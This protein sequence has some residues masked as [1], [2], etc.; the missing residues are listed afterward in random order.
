MSYRP[1]S[2]TTPLQ[3]TTS[4]ITDKFFEPATVLNDKDQKVFDDLTELRR[5]II[6]DM[7]R[8]GKKTVSYFLRFQ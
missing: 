7:E 6:R 1:R 8:E 4:K 5:M 2:S 3:N